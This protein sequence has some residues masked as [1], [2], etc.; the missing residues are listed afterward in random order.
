MTLTTFTTTGL[1]RG[2]PGATQALAIQHTDGKYYAVVIAVAVPSIDHPPSPEPPP[3][4]EPPGTIETLDA[5][6]PFDTAAE[7]VAARDQLADGAR[8]R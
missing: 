7:A 6:G 1:G 4:D 8:V 3:P 5:L 2:M